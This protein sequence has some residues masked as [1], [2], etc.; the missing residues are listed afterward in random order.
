MDTRFFPS[1]FLWHHIM[2]EC[3]VEDAVQ[4]WCVDF[5]FDARIAV[6]F[7]SPL[8][9]IHCPQTIFGHPQAINMCVVCAICVSAENFK[10]VLR[11]WTIFK[12]SKNVCSWSQWSLIGDQLCV[13]QLRIE[14]TRTE[15]FNWL[16]F[17]WHRKRYESKVFV[18]CRFQMILRRQLA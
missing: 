16:P 8:M 13:G 11:Q 14:P 2:C 18:W 9:A 4:I 12:T 3:W 5:G 17:F 10:R 15:I 7:F 1:L 6:Q